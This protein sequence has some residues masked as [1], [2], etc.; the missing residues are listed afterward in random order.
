VWWGRFEHGRLVQH[1]DSE[2]DRSRRR[3]DDHGCGRRHRHDFDNVHDLD[4]VL[5]VSVCRVFEQ[6][7][8]IRRSRLLGRRRR[9]VRSVRIR[10][11]EPDRRGHGRR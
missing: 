8:L 7:R 9:H 11:R 1:R 5:L 2:P 6:R 10:R 4:A 3:L